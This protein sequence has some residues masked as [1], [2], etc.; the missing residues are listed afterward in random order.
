ML[1]RRVG[2]S[3]RPVSGGGSASA[4]RSH[5]GIAGP[6][7]EGR[8]GLRTIPCALDDD[9]MDGMD[10]CRVLD[11]EAMREWSLLEVPRG[12]RAAATASS[13]AVVS[14]SARVS[15]SAPPKTMAASGGLGLVAVL[16]Y[17]GLASRHR[18]A[19]KVRLDREARASAKQRQSL[20]ARY[21][22]TLATES[23]LGAAEG[24]LADDADADAGA[25]AD[26]CGR[27]RAPAFLAHPLLLQART[28]LICIFSQN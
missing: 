8:R 22:T 15:V 14:S 2:P 11:G 13:T 21:R 19:Q 23:G 17:A 6:R 24:P 4:R 25:D 26:G 18:A 27:G 1:G 12:D 28:K 9:D 5:A 10:V 7:L 16:L 3:G 20:M